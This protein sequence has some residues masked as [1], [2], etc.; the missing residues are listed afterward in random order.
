[1]VRRKFIIGSEWIY[2]KLYT[3]PKTIE[4]ILISLYPKI[5]SLLSKKYVDSFHFVRFTDPNYHIRLRLHC[6]NKENIGTVLITIGTALQKYV[7]NYI[8]SKIQIDVYNRELERY[9]CDTMEIIEKFFYRDSDFVIK[10]LKK[11]DGYDTDR[12]KVSMKFINMILDYNNYSLDEKILFTEINMKGYYKEIFGERKE[13]LK[14]LNRQYRLKRNEIN[15]ILKDYNS[16][17]VKTIASLLAQFPFASLKNLNDGVLAS[18]IHMHVNRMFRT[19]QRTVELV[20]YYYLH[21]Y[22][23]SERAQLKYHT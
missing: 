18:L 8:I 2:Y 22:L 17:V 15:M 23:L 3:G 5:Y 10:L 4:S 19:K 16:H 20:L 1:M 13:P 7:D 11:M 6:P 14:C 21:K 12:W 9:G